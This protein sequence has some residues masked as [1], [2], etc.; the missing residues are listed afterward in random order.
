MAKMTILIPGHGRLITVTITD[1]SPRRATI[2]LGN[3]LRVFTKFHYFVN[4][5]RND[6]GETADVFEDERGTLSDRLFMHAPQALV[7]EGIRERSDPD[8]RND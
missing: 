3:D 1:E 2:T 8:E 7:I 5:V 4:E 6:Q